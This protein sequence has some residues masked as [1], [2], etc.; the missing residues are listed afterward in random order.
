MKK[1]TR[2]TFTLTPDDTRRAL[3]E[4]INLH[5]CGEDSVDEDR[6]TIQFDHGTLD[7]FGKFPTVIVTDG[8]C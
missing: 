1:S 2:K 6:M 7:D 8:D 5:S 3:A 4:Y